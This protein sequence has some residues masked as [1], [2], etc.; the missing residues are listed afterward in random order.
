[1]A[2]YGPDFNPQEFEL[3]NYTN[4]YLTEEQQ[5]AVSQT[6]ARVDGQLNWLAQSL[7]WNGPNYWGNLP[8]TP[9]QKRQLLSGSF[10]VYN[11][12][13]VPRILEVQNWSNSVVIPKYRNVKA[14]QNLV[15]DKGYLGYDE[16]Q[17]IEVSETETTLILK[18]AELPPAFY[19]DLANNIQF[20]IDIPDIRPE[21][22]YRPNIGISGDAVFVCGASDTSLTLYPGYDTQKKFPYK[23]PILMLGSTYYFDQYVY[24]SKASNLAED[25]SPTYRADLELWELKIPQ[26]LTSDQVGL[27]AFLVW[28]FSNPD[29]PIL[30][31]LSIILQPWVDPSDW[32]QLNVLRNFTGAWGNKGGALPFNLTFDSLSLHGFNEQNSLLLPTL[33]RAL[34]F[35]Q[36]INLVYYQQIPIGTNGPGNSNTGDIWW[37]NL[38]GALSVR[39]SEPDNCGP[40]VQINYRLA[41]T[42]GTIISYSFPDVAS[43][44]ASAASIETDVFV[45][46]QNVTGLSAAQGV[47]GIQNPLTSP[48]SLLLYKNSANNYWSP[49][50]F[51]YQTEADFAADSLSLPFGV[52]VTLVDVT[53]LAPSAT[54]Y[55]IQNLKITL[56]QN[57]TLV[58]TKTLENDNWV[59]SPD[60]ILKYVAD[61]GLFDGPLQGQM[62]WDF[63]EPDPF[64]RAASIFYQVDWVAVNTNPKI[65]PYPT[66]INFDSLVLYCNGE[67]LEEGQTFQTNDFMLTWFGNI[68]TGNLDF[69]YNPI[70]LV[71]RTNFPTVE[72]SDSLTT[73]YRADITNLLFSGITYYA[74]PNVYDCE[75]PLRLWKAQD[76]QVAE[77]LAHL[78]EDNY[79]NPL[80]ADLNNGPGPENWERYFVRLPLDYARDGDYWQKAALTC[81][82]FGYWGSSLDPEKMRCPPEPGLPA[83]YEELCIYPEQIEDYTYIYSE[84]YW[85]SDVAFINNYEDGDYANSGIFPEFDEEFDDFT[86]GQLISY[87]PFHNRQAKTNVPVGQGYGDWEGIYVNYNLCQRLSGFLVNDLLDR[88][89]SVVRPPVWDASIYK[90]APTCENKPES[91][92]VDSNHYKIGY[93]YFIADA[94]AAE[95]GFFDPQQEAAWRYPVKQPRTE[96]MLPR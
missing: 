37:N 90:F 89:V 44:A 18:F 28:P 2:N 73:A 82:D 66:S 49:T 84:P 10:G 11:S 93:A 56:S 23:S 52:P 94:S 33:E 53:G 63:G 91:Y 26:D 67:L 40:W 51:V 86:E 34:P 15:S 87:D 79:I 80:R 72:V 78:A 41:P 54:T 31:S 96:Y 68:T 85:Y 36:I 48:A 22:F 7:G 14:G 71:G 45:K 13:L 24:M 19:E 16:Y 42:E 62:W 1:M 30:A 4:P 20:K 64:L 5:L 43:F 60:S 32:G 57:Y 61:S 65:N 69:V 46:I 21:P 29:T 17:I 76:L 9:S 12:F 81:Q 8:D 88:A 58:L 27:T 47:I 6:E 75:S 70:T 38:T 59:L 95:E 74:T 50:L 83:I 3:R 92:S 25:Y 55:T 77:T 35:N 39:L